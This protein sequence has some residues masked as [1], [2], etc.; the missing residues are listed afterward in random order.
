[1]PSVKVIGNFTV[2]WIDHEREPQC[3]PNPAYPD[4]IDVDATEPGKPSCKTLLP[5]PARRCGLYYI[6]CDRCGMSYV[7][8]TAGRP[9]DPRSITVPCREGKIWLKV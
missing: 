1:M 9:D 6:K 8:S 4:G 7:V 5:Y 3:A 2:R